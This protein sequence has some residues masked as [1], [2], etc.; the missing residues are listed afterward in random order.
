MPTRS[1]CK[2]IWRGCTGSREP[3]SSLA[4]AL[5]AGEKEVALDFVT[6]VDKVPFY[7]ITDLMRHQRSASKLHSVEL[8]S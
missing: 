5:S 1:L 3:S 6:Q 4:A 2:P 8:V 7:I